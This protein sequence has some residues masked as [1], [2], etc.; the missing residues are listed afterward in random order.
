MRFNFYWSWWLLLVFVSICGGISI[1]TYLRLKRPP[2]A[3]SL[4]RLLI[5][6]RIAAILILVVC[7]LQPIRVEKKDITPV[8]NLLVLVDTT[9]SMT[10]TYTNPAEPANSAVRSKSRLDLVNRWLNQNNLIET[11]ADNVSPAEQIQPRL[12]QFTD[13]V[14]TSISSDQLTSSGQKTD[15]QTAINRVVEQWRGQPVVGL[16]LISDGGHNAT[17]FDMDQI[18]KLNLPIY[19]L[20]VGNP[21]PPADVEIEKIAE[22]Y[23]EMIKKFEKIVED[24][25]IGVFWSELD[26]RLDDDNGSQQ[27]FHA[28]EEGEFSKD[29]SKGGFFNFEG[30]DFPKKM[31]KKAF[32][33]IENRKKILLLK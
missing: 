33:K 24:Y 3:Q 16:V 29:F 2:I 4:K 22:R 12:Y 32:E 19:T 7:L 25:M 21:T 10:L 26:S 5:G 9:P 27:F 6:L 31:I 15:L 23:H 30:I 17:T 28:M 18:T 13:D 8:P 1:I 11:F 20:G 14:V